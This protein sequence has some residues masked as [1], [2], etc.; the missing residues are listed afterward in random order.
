VLPSYCSVAAI[1]DE[2][3]LPVEH[4]T[5]AGDK[6]CREYPLFRASALHNLGIFSAAYAPTILPAAFHEAPRAPIVILMPVAP[7]PS[8]PMFLVPL[9]HNAVC[10]GLSLEPGEPVKDQAEHGARYISDGIETQYVCLGAGVFH[11]VV[12]AIPWTRRPV[13][14]AATT[15]DLQNARESGAPAVWASTSALAGTPIYDAAMRS[16]HRIAMMTGPV[17]SNDLVVGCYASARPV[18][19]RQHARQWST[20]APSP[21]AQAEFDAFL[22]LD[23]ER[24]VLLSA[25]LVAAD[26]GNGR[27]TALADSVVTAADLAAELPVPP[28]GLPTFDDSETLLLLEVP[29]RP[30]PVHRNWL[31]KL[32]AQR[33][34]DGYPPAAHWD[35]HLREWARR[36]TC[37]VLNDNNAYDGQ[38]F[39]NGAAPAGT[40]RHANIVLGK[41]AGRVHE[42]ADGI[43][44]FNALDVITERGADGKM[45]PLDFT[46]ED[47]RVWAFDVIEEFIGSTDDQLV[48]SFL[49]HGVCWMVDAPR[50]LRLFHNLERYDTRAVGDRK[51][52]V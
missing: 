27:L 48:L 47:R 17:W 34:P 10:F 51:S 38:C 8:G 33:V 22:S 46:A 30:P 9:A 6:L 43:G 45:S 44:S 32:P 40:R 31:H 35:Y 14:H 23:R 29:Q 21:N 25:A 5:T 41:G 12:I 28:Q 39:V 13:V 26:S 19:E 20:A 16:V 50:Q 42:H 37:D 2:H 36:L 3:W 24:G 1:D 18:I 15:T 49:F 4:P 11:D 7:S 52:V